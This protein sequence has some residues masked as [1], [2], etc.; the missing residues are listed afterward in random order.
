MYIY[1]LIYMHAIY[2]YMH[3]D[4]FLFMLRREALMDY[5]YE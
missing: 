2:R 5:E 1:I 4:L 3:V